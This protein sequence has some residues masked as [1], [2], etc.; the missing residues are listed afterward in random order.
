MSKDI[1]KVICDILGSSCA[2]WEWVQPVGAT[3]GLIFVWD[4]DIFELEDV[5]KSQRTIAIKLK[6]LQMVW[7]GLCLRSTGLTRT[8]KEVIS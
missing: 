1:D 8:P 6:V 5:F 4:A 2:S 7:F 3:R